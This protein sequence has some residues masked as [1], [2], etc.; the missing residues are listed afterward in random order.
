VI[1]PSWARRTAAEVLQAAAATEQAL[2][3]QID[4]ASRPPA[5]ASE[6]APSE[7]PDVPHYCA[8]IGNAVAIACAMGTDVLVA[9]QPYAL[10]IVRAPHVQQ[11]AEMVA[12]LSQRYNGDRAVAYLN[13]GT[14]I[15][16]AD[17]RLSG[18]GCIR[19]AKATVASRRR[20]PTQCCGQPRP[21]RYTERAFRAG[22][23]TQSCSSHAGSILSSCSI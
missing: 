18:D 9:T 22:W 15:D 5:A 23:K 7:C 11:Q 4:R 17:E 20:S 14:T 19:P 3:R 10:G 16:L 1:R 8:S 6:R 21:I 13:L 12:M 2:E